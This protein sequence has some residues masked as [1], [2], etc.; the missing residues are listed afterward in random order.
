M[1]VNAHQLAFPNATNM[2]PENFLGAVQTTKSLGFTGLTV[3]PCL[4]EGK[5]SADQAG[6]IA[7][8][9]DVQLTTCG[10]LD[11]NKFSPHKKDGMR[12]ALDELAKQFSWQQTFVGLNTGLKTVCG[13]FLEGWRSTEPFNKNGYGEFVGK[14]NDMLVEMNLHGNAEPLQRGETNI[15]DAFNSLVEAIDTVALN[16]RVKVQFDYIHAADQLGPDNVMQWLNEHEALIGLIECGMPGRLRMRETPAFVKVAKWYFDFARNC[17]SPLAVEPFDYEGVIK[18]F[19]L[20]ELY[21]N[22]DNGVD[23]LTSDAEFLR[24]YGIIMN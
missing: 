24:E 21:S 8:A 9:H 23:V 19:C 7:L 16:D 10:F 12:A 3:L 4:M 11:G 13:P 1:Q 2:T 20:E 18:P 15:P 22:K 5:I 17:G 6:K 14:V